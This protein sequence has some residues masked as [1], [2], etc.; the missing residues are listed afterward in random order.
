MNAFFGWLV[1]IWKLFLLIT[2]IYI[3]AAI[4]YIFVI[5]LICKLKGK[6]VHFKREN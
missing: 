4:L 5:R 3:V 2:S 1:D 6:S